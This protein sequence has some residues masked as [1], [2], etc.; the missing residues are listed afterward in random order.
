MSH[1]MS[2]VKAYHLPCGVT[3]MWW[4]LPSNSVMAPSMWCHLPCDVIRH[5]VSIVKSW[6]CW[7][8]SWMPF[9]LSCYSTCQI[10]SPVMLS[11][12]CC[13]TCPLLPVILCHLSCH[14]TCHEVSAVILCHL[15]C[16]L[17]CCDT[18]HVTWNAVT[19][20]AVTCHA[21]SFHLSCYVACH[22][23]CH[24]RPFVVLGYLSFHVTWITD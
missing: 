12:P 24:V 7:S 11:L 22:V 13:P 2:P 20:H 19:W 6:P 15:P 3:C 10:M 1:V 16:H 14:V 5:V 17:T 9:H 23:T 18:C 21:M 8:W 4:H